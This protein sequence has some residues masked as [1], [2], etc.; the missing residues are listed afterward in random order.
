MDEHVESML[1]YLDIQA[2][3]VRYVGIY[4]IG[5]SGKTTLAKTLF[6]QLVAQFEACSFLA[7]IRE[8]SKHGLEHVQRRLICDLLPKHSRAISDTNDG[9][10]V[11]KETCRNK[12]VLI[13][14]DDV[15][16]KEQIESLAG[17][18]GWYSSGSR[19]IIT[20]R[21]I[22]VLG[23]EQEQLKEG[24]GKK[25]AELWT[26]EMTEMNFEQ[27]LQLFS[28][29]AFKM[30]Y[31]P[32]DFLDVAKGVISVIGRF[33]LAL[34][35]IG[36]HLYGKQKEV[37]EDNRNFGERSRL[38]DQEEAWD[39]LKG[40]EGTAKIE[41]LPPLL[42]SARRN[43]G[44]VITVRAEINDLVGDSLAVLDL[45][46]CKI[47]RTPNL[48]K[49]TNLERL[50]LEDCQ[51]LEKIDGTIGNLKRLKHLNLN[52]CYRLQDLPEEIGYLKA[53][54][55][56]FLRGCAYFS[57][58]PASIGDL[59]SL[60]ILELSRVSIVRLP[61]TI[62]RLQKLE[63]L[64]LKYSNIKRLPE[65]LGDV[66]SLVELDL[67]QSKL[68][69]LPDSIG[70]LTKLESLGLGGC[71]KIQKLPDSLGNLGSLSQLDISFTGF[72]ELPDSI[73]NLKELKMLDVSNC[74]E[75]KLPRSIG[76][77]K[78]LEISDARNSDLQGEIPTEIGRLSRLRRLDLS[79][80][81][82][83]LLPWTISQLSL[84]EALWLVNCNKLEELPR[85]P[86]SL[87]GLR[88]ASVILKR[89]PDLSNIRNLTNVAILNTGE[90]PTKILGLGITPGTD[91]IPWVD[92]VCTRNL[93]VWSPCW[94]PSMLE[95]CI[96]VCIQILRPYRHI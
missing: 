8:S 93:A 88:C 22:S 59:Q 82:I 28:S 9:I 68:A 48:S 20:T 81:S 38:W 39:I 94:D 61:D 33:P 32:I 60:A 95:E 16:K 43:N 45:S 34:E 17:S 27:A 12:K 13:V 25:S 37:W 87:T 19:I 11:L 53:L 74:R 47:S 89:I 4:G 3:G 55:E 62:G 73:G 49:Y 24:S 67:T 54:Q 42:N 50:I 57:T 44:H 83:C 40:K 79:S 77:M 58:L 85:L 92:Y 69:Q 86:A 66:Q 26:L 36:S 80:T 46:S 75:R 91:V 96:M 10:K 21:D 6:N 29:H 70:R 78:K 72:L 7:D 76:T 56:L 30:D 5:G 63:R 51:K 90:D 15:D 2:H 52:D 1:K 84:L 14:L 23:V 64:S 71:L 18:S 41:V 35:V 65:T 31:P